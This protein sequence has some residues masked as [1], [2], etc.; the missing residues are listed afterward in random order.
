VLILPMLAGDAGSMLG[1]AKGLGLAAII[2]VL[3]VVV[4]RRVMP[5]ILE[6]ACAS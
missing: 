5:P 1:V 4:A 2:V 6:R 3:V